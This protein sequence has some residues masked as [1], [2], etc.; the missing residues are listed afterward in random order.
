[1]PPA[2]ACTHR[3]PPRAPL[4]DDGRPRWDVA[5]IFRLYGDTYRQSHP[6][7][8]AQHKVIDALLACR[9]ATLGGYTERCA[10]C[11]FER[12]AY[13]SCRNR[14]CPKCQSLPTAQWLEARTADL[15]P[16]P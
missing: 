9:T 8:P 3:S 1:M 14:H 12:S 16:V 2:E 5:D 10:Q 4:V 6:V 13:R 7:S 15:L 11:G